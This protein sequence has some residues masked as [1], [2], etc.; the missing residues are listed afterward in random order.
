MPTRAEKIAFIQAQQAQSQA[1]PTDAGPDQSPQAL[2]A[3]S[4]DQMLSQAKQNLTGDNKPKTR[5]EKIEFIQAQKDGPKSS[6]AQTA[7]EH[8]GQGATVG[9]LPHLQAAAEQVMTPVLNAVTG[10]NVKADDYVTARDR[11][12]K[13]LAQQAKDNPGV[14]RAA[15]LAGGL[16]TGVATGGLMPEAGAASTIG[17]KIAQGALQGA[18]TGAVYGAVANPGDTEGEVNP[19]QLKERAA[20]TAKGAAIGGVVGAAAPALTQGVKSAA[21]KISSKLKDVAEIAAVNATGATGKQASTFDDNAGREL[22][23]RKIVRFGDNQA[24]IAERAGQAVDAAN[25]EIDSSLSKLEKDGVTVD[26]EAVKQRIVDKISKLKTD[27]SQADI[28]GILQKELDNLSASTEAKGSSSFSIKEAEQIKR[29][30]GRKAGDWANPEKAQGG[31]EMYQNFRGAVE[32]AAQKADPTTA[33]AFTEGKKT[34]GLMA[35]IKEAAEKRANTTG[36]SPVGGLADIAS[37]GAGFAKGGY[38]G[39]AVAPIARRVIAPRSASMIAVGADKVADALR[40]I[41]ELADL[42]IKQPA[43]FQA[44]ISRVT[45][46]QDGAGFKSADQKST[47]GPNKWAQDGLDKLQKHDPEALNG[48]TEE[49]LKDPKTKQLLIQASDLS[50]GSKAMD[51]ILT[52]IKEGKK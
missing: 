28:A 14:A 50:P 27:P 16:T 49:Q 31:K 46:Q 44:V 5:A 2:S 19:L 37:I 43:A 34:Y 35:P 25:K 3:M 23:D 33:A 24:K 51:K 26:A 11:N 42:E 22:L 7:L 4:T 15:E 41:P 1:A 52:R 10:N 38:V 12:I 48:F 39:A 40:K 21:S 29:G 9:Y 36:Q 8:F 18:K 30:Y 17:G 45:G 6:E 47:K 13:R 32:D 20:N